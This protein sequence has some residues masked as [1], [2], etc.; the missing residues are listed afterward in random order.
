MF[1]WIK[2]FSE[3]TQDSLKTLELFCQERKIY[4]GQLLFNKWDES[5]SMYIIKKWCMQ[6][7]DGE[8]I[9]WIVRENDM[10]WEMGIFSNH[11]IRMASVKA[12]ED[13]DVIIL[14]DFSVQQ[15]WIKH[16]AILSE[17]RAIISERIKKNT[18]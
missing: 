18:M 15:L 9:L 11:K 8:K 3:L 2:F 12:I 13:T 4:A 1:E 17:I 5:T 14:L 6:V 16:P 7:F 10:V